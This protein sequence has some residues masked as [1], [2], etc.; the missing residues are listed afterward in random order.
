MTFN[1]F[2]KTA[3]GKAPLSAPRILEISWTHRA[4]LARI[5][6]QCRCLCF[7]SNTQLYN[8]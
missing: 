2:F 7:Y 5:D 6:D 3:T 1:N 4:E 8:K